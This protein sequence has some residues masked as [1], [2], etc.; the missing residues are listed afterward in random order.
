MIK[1][2]EWINSFIEM[3]QHPLPTR[4]TTLWPWLGLPSWYPGTLPLSLST[5]DWLHDDVIKW[6]HFRVTDHLCG[7]SPVTDEFP[8]QRPV[9][10]SFDVFFDLHLNKRLSKVA[11][12]RCHRA[13]YDGIVMGDCVLMAFAGTVELLV[14]WVAV[15]GPNHWLP[16]IVKWR[17]WRL[18]P[19]ML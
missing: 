1:N 15:A 8:A 16:V 13:H 4:H 2:L 10:R 18:A 5:S 7:N 19:L 17:P 11:D 6:K 12:L 9:T 3:L 14:K